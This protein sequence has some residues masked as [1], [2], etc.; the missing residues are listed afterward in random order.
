MVDFGVLLFFY[1][2]ICR[3]V[4]GV[5]FVQSFFYFFFVLEILYGFVYCFWWW[6]VLCFDFRWGYHFVLCFSDVVHFE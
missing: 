3:F 2:L 4:L 1:F 6:L 5:L